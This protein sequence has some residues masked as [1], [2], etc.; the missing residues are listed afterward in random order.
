VNNAILTVFKKWWILNIMQWQ[1][2]TKFNGYLIGVIAFF[3]VYAVLEA[4]IKASEN[5]FW[6]INYLIGEKNIPFHLSE[7]NIKYLKFIKGMLFGVVFCLSLV[8]YFVYGYLAQLG[9]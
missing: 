1:I 2:Y 9:Y 3:I 4:S 5:G 7:E 8:Y 6:K